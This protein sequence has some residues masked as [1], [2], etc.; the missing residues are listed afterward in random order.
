MSLDTHVFSERLAWRPRG[1]S[2]SGS[3]PFSRTACD[4]PGFRFGP[5]GSAFSRPVCLPPASAGGKVTV[6]A[7]PAGIQPASRRMKLMPN[8]RVH[9]F[10]SLWYHANWH[11]KN[12]QP[13][14]LP[15]FEATLWDCILQAGRK[16]RGVYMDAVGGT[17]THLHVL[18]R[19]EPSLAPSDQGFEGWQRS[20]HERPIRRR[21]HRLA[22]GLW[23]GHF[24]GEEPFR[25]ETLRAWPAGAPSIAAW[26]ESGARIMWRQH[27]CR[28]SGSRLN[29]GLSGK[30]RSGV[31]VD[32]LMFGIPASHDG[33]S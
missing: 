4:I 17:E 19:M 15:S 23:V 18:F 5:L 1:D 31:V 9:V 3:V 29:A 13:Q 20:R 12:D 26:V 16:E 6:Y 7:H 30:R 21:H 8:R 24:C 10:S 14:I 32:G 28:Q 2:R 22:K 11:C 25:A 33:S 27:G